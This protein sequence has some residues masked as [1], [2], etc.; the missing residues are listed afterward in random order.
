MEQF[1]GPSFP[2]TKVFADGRS[3]AEIPHP[4][5]ALCPGHWCLSR[6]IGVGAVLSKLRN[7]SKRVIAFFRKTLSASERNYCRT[8]KELLT[9]LKSSIISCS[10]CMG[11]VHGLDRSCILPLVVWHKEHSRQVA[12]RPELAE[13][14]SSISTTLADV[15]GTPMGQI[16]GPVSSTHNVD[17]LVSVTEALPGC[18]WHWQSL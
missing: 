14:S 1:G 6:G 8:T 4:L 5:S 9:V 12:W 3:D 7:G 11:R 16:V 15:M 10:T 17:G 2:D 18:K 13:F